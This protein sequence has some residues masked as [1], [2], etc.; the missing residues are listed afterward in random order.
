MLNCTTF[1]VMGDL[2]FAES[3]HMLDNSEYVPWVKTIF[4]GIKYGTRI[5]A[6][7]LLS[8]LNTWL[9]EE[10]LFRVPSLRAKQ[11]EHWGYTTDRVDRRLAQTPD[12]PDLWTRILE[13]GNDPRGADASLSLEEHYSI[14]SLFMIAGTETT[15]TAL[16]GTTFYLLKN[17]KYLKNLQDEL[18]TAFASNEDMHLEPLAKLPLL[19]ATIKEGIRMYPPVPIGLSRISP[20][21]GMTVGSHFVPEGTAIAVHQLSTYRDKSNFK[22]PYEFRPE[23]WL[24]DPEF[25]DDRL[26]AFEPFSVG[27]RNCLGKNLAWHEMR[28]LL[29]TVVLNFDMEIC[30]ESETWADQKVYTLW[31]KPSLMC[32]LK[33]HKGMV[34]S[35]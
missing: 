17:P 22:H 4:G 28:L 18:R 11:M 26:D 31:E 23:R 21:G 29:A 20:P 33:E 12:R 3:L 16:S 24:E 35:A 15:A 13:K 32:R 9:I 25:K 8:S 7:K 1:D 2:T 6:L 27:P 5:R 14:A 30:P 34:S 10:V 19:E